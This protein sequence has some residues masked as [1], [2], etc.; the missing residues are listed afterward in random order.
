MPHDRRYARL[1]HTHEAVEENLAY[2][3]SAL[4]QDENLE[5]LRLIEKQLIMLNDYMALMTD[6]TVPPTEHHDFSN[7]DLRNLDHE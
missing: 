2:V 4:T 7:A 3:I 6:V 1:I 5:T